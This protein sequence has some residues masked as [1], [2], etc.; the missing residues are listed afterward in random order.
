MIK[1]GEIIKFFDQVKQE[2]KKITWP[3]K[4]DLMTSG[5]IVIVSVL[6]FSLITMLLDYTIHNFVDFLLN[7]GK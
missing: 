7:I 6:I 1:I 2:A 4:K 5:S 3:D